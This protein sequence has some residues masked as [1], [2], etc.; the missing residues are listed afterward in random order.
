MGEQFDRVKKKAKEAKTL[1]EDALLRPWRIRGR[2][3]G[4]GGGGYGTQ[5]LNPV[6]TVSSSASE[7]WQDRRHAHRHEVEG[8]NA[9]VEFIGRG[10]EAST[11]NAGSSVCQKPVQVR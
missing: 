9:G 5:A 6:N 7:V 11:S 10:Y 2:V 3:R 1:Q 4:T 8:I